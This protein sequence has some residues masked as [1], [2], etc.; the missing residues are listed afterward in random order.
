MFADLVQFVSIATETLKALNEKGVLV[1]EGL[2]V[3]YDDKF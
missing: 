3:D 2:I 1:Q